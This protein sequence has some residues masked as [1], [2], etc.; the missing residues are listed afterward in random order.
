MA[1]E[2]NNVNFR[3]ISKALQLKNE[4]VVHICAF[5]EL[6]VTVSHADGWRR[7]HYDERNRYRKMTNF[8][9]D[10]FCKGLESKY[11]AEQ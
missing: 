4:D 7:P 3:R 5:A 6:E 10:M 1:S 2:R 11:A 9:F 8:E